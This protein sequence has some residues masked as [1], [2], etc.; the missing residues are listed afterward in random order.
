MIIEVNKN[1]GNFGIICLAS[2]SWTK[3]DDDGND[4]DYDYDSCN[5]NIKKLENNNVGSI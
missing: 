3:K 5:N 1:V 4:D 2:N